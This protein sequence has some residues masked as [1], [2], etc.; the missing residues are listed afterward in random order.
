LE[1]EIMKAIQQNCCILLEMDANA[2][3]E[4]EFQKLSENGKLLIDLCGRQD[5]KIIN[6]SPLCQGVITRHRIT[7]HKEEKSTLDYVI[8]CDVL[9]NYVT[10]MLID[11]KRMFT[12]TKFV[13]TRG[14]VKKI[15]S[16]HNI[17]YCSFN[18]SYKKE[19]R[20]FSR[21]EIFNLKSLECQRLFNGET[22]NTSKFTD[23]FNSEDPFERKASNFQMCLNQSIRK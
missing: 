11:E 9:A 23:I 5:L 1:K 19:T 20:R 16:D 4:T 7:K 12:L 14:M 13:S 18:I 15:E 3:I 17:L 22:E 6:N 21:K 8:V 10:N 2:K